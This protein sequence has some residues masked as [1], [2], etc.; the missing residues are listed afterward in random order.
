MDESTASESSPDPEPIPSD[1]DNV[2]VSGVPAIVVGI[3]NNGQRECIAPFAHLAL[4][5]HRDA[6][7]STAFIKL[8]AKLALQDRRNKIN[9]FLFMYPERIQS[10]ELVDDDEYQVQAQEKLGGKNTYCL[11]FCLNQA[12]ALIVPKEVL[13]VP[14]H[15]KDVQVLRRMKKLAEQKTLAVYLSSATMPRRTLL[16]LCKAVISCRSMQRHANLTSLYGGKGGKILECDQP[17]PQENEGCP[18]P[19]K[20]VGPSPPSLPYPAQSKD[21]ALSRRKKRRRVNSDADATTDDEPVSVENICLRIFSRMD[22]GFKALNTRLEGIEHRLEAL[23]AARVNTTTS[24]PDHSQ[25]S[26]EL[27]DDLREVIDA[28][29][30]DEMNEVKQ[31]LN[32][33]MMDEV[34]DVRETL[35][36]NVKEWLGTARPRL[37]LEFDFDET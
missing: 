22:E 23:E 16:S 35:K 12:A 36:G 14:K 5:L 28:R 37:E 33:W 21:P 19:Y 2:D 30:D 24:S 27:I 15:D 10:L 25:S 32:I 20:E 17:E 34:A 29:I 11:R 3:G 13:M 1:I 26:S 9:L 31:D 4:D 8:R 18:P 7:S 6:S